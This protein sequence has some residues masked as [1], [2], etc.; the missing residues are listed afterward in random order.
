[1]NTFHM[2]QSIAVIFSNTKIWP[3]ESLSK[4]QVAP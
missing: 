3:L 1:M 4:I 2:F